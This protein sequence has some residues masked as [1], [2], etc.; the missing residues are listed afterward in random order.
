MYKFNS[1]KIQN[2]TTSIKQKLLAN[3]SLALLYSLSSLSIP[4]SAFSTPNPKLEKTQNSAKP[5]LNFDFRS[6]VD[7][8]RNTKLEIHKKD[9]SFILP[10]SLLDVAKKTNFNNDINIFFDPYT[11]T[12][13][14]TN[15]VEMSNPVSMM[16]V[17]FLEHI[18]QT[19]SPEIR[20]KMIELNRVNKTIKIGNLNIVL[21]PRDPTLS[22][23]NFPKNIKPILVAA[24]NEFGD[25]YDKK[26]KKFYG[27]ICNGAEIKDKNGAT[28]LAIARH[29][30]ED[31]KKGAPL[32]IADGIGPNDDLKLLN[33]DVVPLVELNDLIILGNRN[34]K[35]IDLA[36]SYIT[37]LNL[38]YLEYFSMLKNGYSDN[39]KLAVL[40]FRGNTEDKFYT[41]PIIAT[42][43]NNT[44]PFLDIRFETDKNTSKTIGNPTLRNEIF[45]TLSLKNPT[46]YPNSTIL[47]PDGASGSQI[48]LITTKTDKQGKSTNIASPIGVYTGGNSTHTKQFLIDALGKNVIDKKAPYTLSA[49]DQIQYRA[50]FQIFEGVDAVEYQALL[51][52]INKQRSMIETNPTSNIYQSSFQIHPKS[53]ESNY[54]NLNPTEYLQTET[55]NLLFNYQEDLDDEIKPE[56]LDFIAHKLDQL[57]FNSERINIAIYYI[58][59]EFQ[60]MLEDLDP[61]KAR[62]VI[63]ESIFT[64]L[65]IYLKSVSKEKYP[66]TRN[67]LSKIKPD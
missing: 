62:N 66:N 32:G 29:C 20:Q 21:T 31:L 63:D 4:A 36:L 12:V 25:I 45:T 13:E 43:A 65:T 60:D 7:T 34:S 10:K 41:A 9:G 37:K 27:L 14:V 33:K 64:Q 28:I 16:T 53:S 8:H 50:S 56:M 30:M 57:L 40:T 52:Q 26:T 49:D 38:S 22:F 23:E 44:N 2:N 17:Y 11:N 35:N 39:I 48:F 55:L 61:K 18:L 59:K 6:F 47:L 19:S 42:L 1:L 51:K 24:E 46:I 67:L 58:N 3:L 15:I 54:A 5:F